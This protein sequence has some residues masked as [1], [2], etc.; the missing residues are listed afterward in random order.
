MYIC[1]YIYIYIYIYVYVYVYIYDECY[2]FHLFMNIS[3]VLFVPP[4]SE[5]PN[6]HGFELHRPPIKGTKLIFQ[7]IKAIII[8]DIHGYPFSHKS[9]IYG[10]GLA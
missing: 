5:N 1:I 3:N 10:A 9:C 4:K 7:V 8:I 2:G 6:L